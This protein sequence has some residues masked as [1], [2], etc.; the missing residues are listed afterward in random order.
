[1]PGYLN[2]TTCVKTCPSSDMTD[3]ETAKY[4]QSITGEVPAKEYQLDC[5]TN[6]L[7]PVC[8]GT[9]ISFADLLSGD[10]GDFD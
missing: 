6:T 10:A 4:Y 8:Y 2:H 7:V 1:M 3:T 5:L 9:T